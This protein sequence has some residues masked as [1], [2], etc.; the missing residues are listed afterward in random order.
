MADITI[1]PIIKIT[2]SKKLAGS[3]IFSVWRFLDGYYIWNKCHKPYTIHKYAHKH[4]TL[5]CVNVWLI[6]THISITRWQLYIGKLLASP[7]CY[8][9][10]SS[11]HSWLD[12]PWWSIRKRKMW[13]VRVRT[14]LTMLKSD[15]N[16]HAC[17]RYWSL[18]ILCFIYKHLALS[19]FNDNLIYSCL[20]A[21]QNLLLKI[22]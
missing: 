9:L 22:V 21:F 2:R 16:Q 11:L 20:N 7:I 18:Y 8:L 4:E 10:R 19:I 3:Q 6:I 1:T 5:V 14:L 15:F 17:K 13:N 12:L